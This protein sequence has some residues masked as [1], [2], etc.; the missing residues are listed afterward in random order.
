MTFVSI[1]AEHNSALHCGSEGA[2][3]ARCATRSKLPFCTRYLLNRLRSTGVQNTMCIYR[4][5]IIGSLSQPDYL[6]QA[7][8][9]R[10]G[11]TAEVKSAA[12]NASNARKTSSAAAETEKP[13]NLQGGTLLSP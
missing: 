10:A 2:T 8:V 1:S 6:K 7:R 13:S 12:Q 3:A 9:R 11:K 5:E 4:A